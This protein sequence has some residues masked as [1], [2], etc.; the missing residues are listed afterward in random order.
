MLKDIKNFKYR[1]VAWFLLLIVWTFL[2]IF[3]FIWL[4]QMALKSGVAARAYPPQWIFHPTISNFVEI[5]T[6]TRFFQDLKNSAIIAF[7]ATV[8]SLLIGVPAAYSLSRR[9]FF[10]RSFLLIG[11][12]TIRVV[13]GL[14]FA[15]PYFA[16]LRYLGLLDTHLGLIIV[17]TVF[18]LALV[19]FIMISFFNSIPIQL[20]EAATIDGASK[21]QTFFRVVLP[22]S[23]PGLVATS[24]L[25]FILSWNDFIYALI[26]T[27]RVARTAPVGLLNFAA[28]Q[29]IAWPKVSAGALLLILPVVVFSFVLRRYLI[30]GLTAGAMKG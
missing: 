4:G 22:I 28:Y 19:I 24:I 2:T 7:G 21:T 3:P 8:L 15:I 9:R 18:N 23:T 30:R 25:C 10:G 13:P 17:Y 5:I 1:K 14:T 12:L 27:R 29:G 26:L 20:E 16:L 6:E 11:T